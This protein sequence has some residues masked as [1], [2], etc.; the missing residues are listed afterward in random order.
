M[1]LRLALLL[2]LGTFVLL[3]SRVL[4]R[5]EVIFPHDNALE[6]GVHVERVDTRLSNRKFSDASSVFIPEL[7]NNLSANHKAWLNTWN[8][9]VELGRPAFQ[10]SGLSRAYAL[11]NLLSTLTSDPFVLYS[12]LVL[13]TVG[14][15]ACFGLLF[16]RALGL[17]PAACAVGALGLGFS[18]MMMYWLTFIMFLSAI[19]WSV[20]LLWLITEFTRKRSWPAALGLAFATYSLLLTGYPQMTVLL[21]YMIAAYTLIRLGQMRS[22]LREKLWRTLQ[23]SGC[24]MV[25]A[26]ASLPVYLDLIATARDSARLSGVR[27]SFFLA[28]LPPHHGIREIAGFVAT[29][30]DWS[31]LGNAISPAFPVPFNGLSFTPVFGSLVWLS[32][33]LKSRRELWFWQIFLLVCLAGTIFPSLYLFA[34]HHLGFGFSR[35]QVLSGAIVPGFVLSAYAVDAV[36]RGKIRLTIWSGSWLLLPLA[37]EVIVAL[38]VWRQSPLQPLAVGVTLLFVLALLAATFWRSVPVFLGVAV[39][40]VLCYG[41][42]LILS[43]PPSTIL[44]SSV[45]V[46]ALKKNTDGARFA[47][48]DPGIRDAL[49]PNEE[50]LFGLKSIN[51]YDSLSPRR[52]QELVKRWSA[53]GTDTYGRYFKIINPELALADPSFGLANVSIVLSKQPLSSVGLKTAGTVGGIQFYRPAVAP[54]TLRQTASYKISGEDVRMD[55]LLPQWSLPSSRRENIDDF[56][57]IQVTAWPEDTLL[58]V[59][60]QYHPG[61]R[62][63]AA[64]RPLRT[65]MVNQFYQGVI[66]PPMTNEVE[67]R[68]RPFV[69][70]SWLP[71]LFFAAGAALLLLGQLLNL[72][73]KTDAVRS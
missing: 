10:V 71:Q 13:L 6:A 22:P 19:C 15:T 35:I 1:S 41:R 21:T 70:W 17:H 7:A 4:F 27:D 68:F 14:L 29:I 62:A 25:G 12:M 57:K 5:A 51:S 33:L 23:L 49:P 43:R 9:H 60:Q 46:E 18:T 38:I 20:C 31:W 59:S 48:A 36:L 3:F 65:V 61:W 8:P 32:F 63:T 30:F 53:Q 37:G 42:P 45:L 24:A 56:Q 72:R 47:I 52:Y 58:F 73:A 26:L 11:T 39:L 28:V 66:V 44:R 64:Q 55:P 40:S 50:A 69:V 16:L 2:V 34:V 54:I 67:L